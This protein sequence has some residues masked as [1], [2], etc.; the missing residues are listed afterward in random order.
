MNYLSQFFNNKLTIKLWISAY[1]VFCIVVVF[2]TLYVIIVSKWY[3]PF[4][5]MWE[6]VGFLQ[7]SINSGLHLEQLLE[8]YAYSHRLLIPKLLFYSDYLLFKG[9]NTSVL[10]VSIA[11][12]FIMLAVFIKSLSVEKLDTSLRVV[13]IATLWAM[14]FFGS[15]YYNYL[16]TFD[17][18]WFVVTASV[19]SCFFTITYFKGSFQGLLLSVLF[20]LPG[21]LSNF[22]ALLAIPAL[23]LFIVASDKTAKV[24]IIQCAL[25]V[26]ILSIY[27]IDFHNQQAGFFIKLGPNSIVDTYFSS[28]IYQG[29]LI[30]LYWMTLFPIAFLSNPLSQSFIGLWLACFI[31]FILLIYFAALWIRVIFKRYKPS[32]YLE[33]IALLLIVYGYGVGFSVAIGRGWVFDTVYADRFQNIVLLFW[34]GVLLFYVSRLT[35]QSEKNKKTNS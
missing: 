15:L 33:W 3:G 9:T 25:C 31:I 10:F 26:F 22:S 21:M 28:G 24:K 8:P 23:M 20:L 18:Q 34:M 1:V 13:T 16:Y 35:Y 14:I 7:I 19:V 5:D 29:L 30:V 4:R 32:S 17:V 11:C 6:L 2:S 12:Q 27:F